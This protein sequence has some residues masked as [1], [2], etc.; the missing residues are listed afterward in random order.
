MAVTT[1]LD[2]Q[3]NDV[4]EWT[5]IA[6]A[7]ADTVTASIAHGFPQ[8]GKP[9]PSVINILQV[10]AALSLW[11][12]TTLDQTNWIATKAT[13]AGSGNAGAQVRIRMERRR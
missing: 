2:F 11:A 7:D 13:T 1:T 4:K 12:V 9:L 10:P 6:T 5:I 3:T 8:G